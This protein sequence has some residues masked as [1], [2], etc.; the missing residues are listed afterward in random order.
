MRILQ[1]MIE[2]PTSS[3]NGS[4][5]PSMLGFVRLWLMFAVQVDR[6]WLMFAVQV[7]RAL[8]LYRETPEYK[9]KKN[10]DFHVQVTRP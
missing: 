9:N 10:A 2:C 3:K 6:L 7:D 5:Q 8:E 1:R 4:M